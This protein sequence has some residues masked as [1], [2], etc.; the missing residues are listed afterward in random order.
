[1]FGGRPEI[2][3][4]LGLTVLVS[5]ADPENVDAQNQEPRKQ[6][7]ADL[8]PPTSA[9]SETIAIATDDLPP[10]P[11]T[12]RPGKL[13]FKKEGGVV[14]RKTNEFELQCDVY[15][16]KGEGPYPAIL[17]VHGGAWRRGSKFIML[18]HAWK[19]AQAG[20]VVVAINYRHAPEY[21]FPAQ[22][23]DCKH[24]VRWMRAKAAEYKIDP[25]RIGGYGYSAGGHLV[26]LLGTTD[27]SDGLEGEIA[28]GF[29]QFD[30]RI[31]CVAAGGSP[32]EFS[33]IQDDSPV[34]SYWLGGTRNQN[35]SVYFVASPTTYVTPDDPPFF[36]YHGDGDWLVP[37]DSSQ[38]LHRRLLETQVPSQ[39]FIAKSSGHVSTFSDLT[40]MD[41][42]IEFFDSNLK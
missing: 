36:L 13:E 5:L 17:A 10:K 20:Y 26:S 19:M 14:Y 16:P 41:K 42:A 23:H 31:K 15:I 32:C 7:A 30:T 37:V 34:L 22:I 24:A 8:C 9:Q 6:S 3:I 11:R 25:E 1:M 29:E 18:R 21:R 12:A 33:W 2:L 38:K 28:T 35:T 39:H 4:W 27:A 40:W